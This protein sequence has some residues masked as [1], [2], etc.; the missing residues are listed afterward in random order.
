MRLR[1]TA[2]VAVLATT[3]LA[4]TALLAGPAPAL[5]GG[6]HHGPGRSP[7]VVLTPLGTYRTGLFDE[8]GSEIT[9]HDPA[10]QRLFVVSSGAGTVDVLDISRPARP[11]RVATL[12]TPGANS[13]AVHRGLVAVA[14]EADDKTAPGSLAF[15]DA[16][17]GAERGRVTVGALP[18]M[19][20]FT[21]DGHYAVVANEGEPEGYCA[22]QSDPEGS[23]SVVDLRRGPA[24]AVVRTADFHR[25]DRHA[26]RLRAAGVRVFGPGATVS[27]DLEPEYVTTDGRTAWVTLQEN[28]AVAT[29][30]LRSARVTR[31]AP[32]GTKDHDTTG[33]GLDASDKDGGVHIAPR[34]VRGLYQPDSLGH[35][36][37]G[38]HTY[39]V[40]ANEGDAREYDCFAEEER[41]ADLT[42]DPAAFPDAAALQEKGALGRLTV[43]T[44]S[45]HGPDGYTGLDAFGARSVS[46]RDARTGRLVWDS[47][48]ALEQLV[49]EQQPSL[50]NANNDDNDSVDSRSDDK[51]PEPEGLDLGR[52]RGR[53]Y[54]FVGLERT[55]GIVAIDVT[56]PA[57]GRVAG[58]A[59]NRSTDPAADA[60]AG[61]AGD[62][63][64]EGVLFIPASQSP[65]RSPLLV[66]GNEVSGTTTI[67]SVATR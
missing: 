37:S 62:L 23:V 20:T 5:A 15:F 39:L 9:A 36:T 44:T 67:W 58:Y 32:L 2:P 35:Y 51:G 38:G 57:H 46:V 22:G 26:D 12:D 17:T 24:R 10:T 13:V 6:H 41:V 60:E 50:F 53:T 14:E 40:T 64:P 4:A 45:A 21:P 34:P 33:Q 65:N 66:V 63:G 48:D 47:G 61:E 31:I 30:D 19:V 25:W 8:G 59:S 52:L 11:R 29:V 27:Q 55:S 42:L 56:D 18:D 16:R 54:A 7:E 1:P 43:T 28:N 3:S 49:A